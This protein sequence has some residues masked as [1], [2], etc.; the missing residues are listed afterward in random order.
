[1]R[2]SI[3]VDPKCTLPNICQFLEQLSAWLQHLNND[4]AALR[5]AVCNV[6]KQAFSNT[7]INAKPPRFCSDAPNEPA[8]PVP[9]GYG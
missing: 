4:Y 7:G 2:P 8:P 5:I 3:S 6:E 1:M 9:F